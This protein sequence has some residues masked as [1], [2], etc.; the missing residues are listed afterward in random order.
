MNKNAVWFAV[1]ILGSVGGFYVI[2]QD[3]SLGA[4]I[5]AGIAIFFGGWSACYRSGKYLGAIKD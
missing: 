3:A 5:S 1:S 2:A 4:N